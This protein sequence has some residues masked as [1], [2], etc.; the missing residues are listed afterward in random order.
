MN[1]GNKQIRSRQTGLPSLVVFVVLIDVGIG[2]DSQ[3]R[4]KA[5]SAKVTG[6]AGH[7]V[8]ALLKFPATF[9]CD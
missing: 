2:V 9:A 4:Q 6:K 7:S 5:S 3:E 8:T 1:V